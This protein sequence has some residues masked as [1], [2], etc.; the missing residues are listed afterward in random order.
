MPARKG[1][2]STYLQQ[3]AK[4]SL[5]ETMLDLNRPSYKLPVCFSS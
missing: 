2:N 4:Y 3:A 5:F 1:F